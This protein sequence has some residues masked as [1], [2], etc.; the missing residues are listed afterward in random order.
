MKSWRP[1]QGNHYDLARK[2]CNYWTNFAKTGDPNGPDHDGTP[3]PYWTPFT[4]E[5]PQNIE[6]FDKISMSEGPYSEKR[7]FLIRINKD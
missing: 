7:A 4:K 2:I 6:L 1:F 3:M 5:S